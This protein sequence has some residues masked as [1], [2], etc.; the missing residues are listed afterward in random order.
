MKI[1]YL[2]L[3]G[4]GRQR[5]S[6]TLNLLGIEIVDDFN[7]NPMVEG[8]QIECFANSSVLLN[9]EEAGCSTCLFHS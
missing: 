5:C 9:W 1:I 6:W 8:D 3:P 7:L 4:T 2:G